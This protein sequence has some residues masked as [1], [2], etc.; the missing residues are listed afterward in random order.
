M[1][2]LI[3]FQEYKTDLEQEN[4]SVKSTQSQKC[5]EKI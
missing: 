3:L 2:K 5:V 1:N 4:L